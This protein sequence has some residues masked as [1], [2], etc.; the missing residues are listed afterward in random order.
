MSNM[1]GMVRASFGCYNDTGDVDRLLEMLERIAR[2]DY[3]GTYELNRATGE[4]RPANF[5]EN[6][7]DSFLLD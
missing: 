3:A 5:M 2:H 6:L 7:S 4:Y 1:P